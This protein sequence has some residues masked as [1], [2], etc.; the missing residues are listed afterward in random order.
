[1]ES[2]A[3]MNPSEVP[4]EMGK[5]RLTLLRR[6][7]DVVGLPSSRINTFERSVVADL[8]IEV[9]RQAPLEERVRVASRLSQLTEIPNNLCRMLL[10]D[11]IAVASKLIDDNQAL[12]D[13]D[14][15]GCAKDAS[16]E[17]C[18][19]IAMRR[20]VSAAL[21]DALIARNNVE[22][23]LKVL[24]NDFA[25]IPMTALEKIVAHS[26]FHPELCAAVLK[27]PELRP[28][29]AYMIFW[30]C[31]EAERAT[32]LRRFAVSR[33][34]LQSSV[35]DMFKLAFSDSFDDPVVLKALQFIERRQRRRDLA[36][37]SPYGGLEGL[38]KEASVQGMTPEIVADIGHLAGIRPLTA[39]KILSDEG[40]EAMAVLCKATGLTRQYLSMLWKAMRHN[41][42][43]SEEL[44][45][46][47][48]ERV[49]VTYEM[50]AVDRAQTVIR[51]WNWALTSAL[52]PDLIRAIREGEDHLIDEF[53]AAERAA[54]L[55][56]G[57]DM[58]VE[59]STQQ[60]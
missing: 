55:A 10:R 12:N 16:L 33:E 46:Q 14:L 1:M 15:M 39:A 13:F 7:S 59:T 21:A 23:M 24:A 48:W 51:Y 41:S 60:L 9:L 29:S 50:L 45:A 25:M 4:T 43:G 8:L 27:R 35:S 53:S 38:I 2:A 54:L 32:I 49:Q 18:K 5:E 6:L 28:S 58:R 19:H 26:R 3:K 40:G 36:E 11:D 34:V 17:H 56:L 44:R 31:S 22:V 57:A 30:W 20:P 37:A 42:A 52:T 47:R